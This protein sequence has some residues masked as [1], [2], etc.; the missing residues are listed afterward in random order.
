MWYALTMKACPT[1]LGLATLAACSPPANN[2]P[3]P[4][5]T[6]TPE[7]IEA[8]QLAPVG[9]L[10]GE[11]RVAGINDAAIDAPIGLAL[12][13]SAQ[14]IVFDGPCGGAAWDYQLAGTRLRTS[15]VTSPDHDCLATARAYNLAIALVSALDAATQAGRTPSNGIELSSA[16]RSVTL[17]SQ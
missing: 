5:P 12:S 9:T 15:R 14:R 6:P 4:T 8:P 10:I 3:A 11:Y 7:A 17:Y 2:S 13:I 1:L 16:D